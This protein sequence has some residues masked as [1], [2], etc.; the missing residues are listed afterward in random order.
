MEGEGTLPFERLKQIQGLLDVFDD[1][2]NRPLIAEGEDIALNPAVAD[3][4]DALLPGPDDDEDAFKGLWDTVI[5]L[6]GREAVK[7]DEA[8]GSSTWEGCCTIAR[9]LIH[10]DFLSDGA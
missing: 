7:I 8:R 9:L 5:E 3:Q 6:H 10:Y 4:L 1:D 2:R